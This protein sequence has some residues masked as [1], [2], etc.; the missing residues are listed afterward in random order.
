M[1]PT[2]GSLKTSSNG[3]TVN[4][5]ANI[6][7]I[8][9]NTDNITNR[10]YTLVC[11]EPINKNVIQCTNQID[12]DNYNNK[13]TDIMVDS[14]NEGYQKLETRATLPKVHPKGKK[15][16][17]TWK[18]VSPN[19]SNENIVGRKMSDSFGSPKRS[20]S[21]DVSQSSSGQT[22]TWKD[23]S[24]SKVKGQVRQKPVRKKRPES[25]YYSND[26]QSEGQDS[27]EEFDS[28]S[29]SDQ[30][31]NGRHSSSSS[32]DDAGFSEYYYDEDFTVKFDTN[33]RNSSLKAKEE[34]E[35][36][37]PPSLT[38]SY[39]GFGNLRESLS[40]PDL[41][42]GNYESELSGSRTSMEVSSSEREMMCSSDMLE[43]S[44][45]P[46]FT[47]TPTAEIGAQLYS[48][49]SLSQNQSN[50]CSRTS[51]DGKLTVDCCPRK[52]EYFLSFNSSSQG[53]STASL[54]S[55]SYASQTSSQDGLATCSPSCSSNEGEEICSNS[56]HFC[57]AGQNDGYS[58]SCNLKVPSGKSGLDTLEERSIEK[59]ASTEASK[60]SNGNASQRSPKSSP[61]SSP[62]KNSPKSSPTK[63]GSKMTP[64]KGT[65]G[66]LDG[67]QKFCGTDKQQSMK[68]VKKLTSWKQVKNLKK[69]GILC[70]SSDKVHS[71]PDLCVQTSWGTGC[72]QTLEQ[73]GLQEIADSFH[74][75]R[76]S[77]SLLE[78]Y[79]RMKSPSSMVSLDTIRAVE[80]I[81]FPDNSINE[82]FQ[83]EYSGNS[84]ESSFD[85]SEN[86]CGCPYQE[87][88]RCSSRNSVNSPIRYTT[89]VN[90]YS[91]STAISQ[92]KVTLWHGTRNF[93]S[94]FP[95]KTQ[96]CG[97]QACMDGDPIPLNDQSQQT[98]P[99]SHNEI[100]NIL[101]DIG[102][103][104]EP[105]KPEKEAHQR[106]AASETR[107]RSREPKSSRRS[108]SLSPSRHSQHKFY[109]HR[110]LPDLSFL[111]PGPRIE[112][113]ENS[114][115]DPVKIPIILTPVVDDSQQTQSCQ[116]ESGYCSCHK[117]KRRS[118]RYFES[119]S[120]SGIS[121]NSTSSCIDGDCYDCR[122]SQGMAKDLERI[123]FQPPHLECAQ[124]YIPRSDSSH[125]THHHH[126]HHDRTDHSGH[127][128]HSSFGKRKS[129]RKMNLSNSSNSSSSLHLDKLYSV[130]EES[131]TSPEK[132]S[133]TVFDQGAKLHGHVFRGYHLS[134]NMEKRYHNREYYEIEDDENSY[135]IE[136]QEDISCGRKPL[137][138]C[139]RKMDK[140]CRSRSLSNPDNLNAQLNDSLKMPR[141]PN[142]YSIACDSLFPQT[143]DK[144]TDIVEVTED[145]K[146]EVPFAAV[147]PVAEEPE[148]QAGSQSTSLDDGSKANKRV[149]FASEV[150]FQ[151]PQCSPQVSPHRLPDSAKVT[152]IEMEDEE[153][154]IEI[155]ETVPPEKP[156]RLFAE[157]PP[158]EFQISPTLDD[159]V[160]QGSEELME[161]NRK[162]AL[163][164][165]ITR[166]A[167]TL[168]L[169]FAQARDPFDKLRLGSVAETP[170]VG[171]LVFKELCPAMEQVIEDGMKPHR[172]GIHVF[173]KIHITPWRIAEMSAEVG[174]YTRSINTLV[175][176]LKTR[177]NLLSNKQRFYA[178]IAG[179]LNLRL[180]DF[181]VGYIQMKDDLK[182]QVYHPEAIL[183]YSQTKLDKQ[184]NSMILALQPLSTLPFQLDYDLVAHT[185]AAA[186]MLDNS[187]DGKSEDKT[188]SEK[189][190]TKSAVPK[191]VSDSEQL[192]GSS[193]KILDSFGNSLIPKAKSV[194]SITMNKIQDGPKKL[195]TFTARKPVAGKAQSQVPVPKT[196]PKV[197]PTPSRIPVGSSKI[198]Q[199]SRIP[200]KPTSTPKVSQ[201]PVMQKS[202]DSISSTD[203]KGNKTTWAQ[204]SP[205][206][207]PTRM[208]FN[209]E[210]VEPKEEVKEEVA[211]NT[212]VVTGL[213]QKF[214]E[215]RSLESSAGSVEKGDDS[216]SS[217]SMKAL[218]DSPT[219]TVTD[220]NTKKTIDIT[221]LIDKLLLS[222][223]NIQQVK[224]SEQTLPRA[225]SVSDEVRSAGFDTKNINKESESVNEIDD[226]VMDSDEQM[227]S[228]SHL[229]AGSSASSFAVIEAS[230]IMR[231][232]L[233]K[234]QPVKGCAQ[235]EMAMKRDDFRLTEFRY[236][237]VLETYDS[238]DSDYLSYEKGDY[239]EV[240]AQLDSTLLYCAKGSQEGLVQL[241]AIRPVTDEDE[242]NII[243]ND[244]YQ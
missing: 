70:T 94:Q 62:K 175:K 194:T 132:H 98:S 191:S 210:F 163:L 104:H 199:P 29:G 196:Q 169:H 23:L 103:D 156:K 95:P 192:K 129:S 242:F 10:N 119:G 123:L 77:S 46:L 189:V 240:L 61:K 239:L 138:S 231:V 167:E 213:T 229:K 137:K 130:K 84:S 57:Q 7:N 223:K 72:K 207:S 83:S 165:N 15:K 127:D 128:H 219:K 49:D 226:A 12:N 91:R 8:L 125:G 75:K 87:D 41:Y 139:L 153:L 24:P 173:G 55:N 36:A 170:E 168:V 195:S 146:E 208:L 107:Q 43:F 17:S 122:C 178:F 131:P 113:C 149:S 4:N 244:F 96:E 143:T 117:E 35:Y 150:L 66:S 148:E 234:P 60:S 216:S 102:V 21:W 181:W 161:L 220:G 115:F 110:S 101:E 34:E 69:F 186:A 111:S 85:G 221:S 52:D 19:S 174:P 217:L 232:Q 71:M 18:D 211:S 5:G 205:T 118:G 121:T 126:H 74:N 37:F 190:G 38:G 243:H 225:E 193:K 136:V 54:S 147:N 151:S 109:S 93:S 166:A 1:S 25:G 198:P 236:G 235:S 64:S 28:L 203:S 215:N 108:S 3:N 183:R 162:I 141:K 39:K 120:S 31:N 86:S 152:N 180:L 212:P 209:G 99:S 97:I 112:H 2:F 92:D 227:K 20:R 50:C 187:S 47:P 42:F 58:N 33:I 154:R 67:Q 53:Q 158:V 51:G 133:H 233:P 78:L 200:T 201:I 171:T 65:Y 142:R 172:T 26:V 214:M 179:L 222:N 32:P 76:H 230:P 197:Q 176:Q 68:R 188:V 238:E 182:E 116:K 79:Q 140:G 13:A 80:Q 88:S 134:G 224:S 202:T 164:S 22:V 59:S 81:L 124:K 56:F 206:R 241:T 106:K 44:N 90:M 114:L 73:R 6:T 48:T 204:Q 144:E 157:N 159:K 9:Q 30:M 184:Y 237:K 11:V 135:S 45:D 82:R 16:Y 63:E 14:L 155:S 40:H 228:E 177:P 218:L 100:L 89:P 145:P 185:P 27:R 160:Q 105:R